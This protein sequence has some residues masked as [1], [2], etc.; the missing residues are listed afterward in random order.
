[1]NDEAVLALARRFLDDMDAHVREAPTFPLLLD[2]AV[3]RMEFT[4]ALGEEHHAEE[5]F[6]AAM[7]LLRAGGGAG[8]WLYRGAAQAGWTALRLARA[9]GT[10]PAGLGAVDDTVLR[11]ITDYPA[12]GEVDLPMGVLGL[13]VY[14]LAHPDAGFRDKA[15]AG[16]LDVVEERVERDD[17]G[18]FL[19]LSDSA[20][21]RAD[22]SALCRVLG[23][24]HG[25]AGLVSYLASAA[26]TACAP[27][28]RPL[29]D[30]TV[31]WLR[32]RRGGFTHSVFPHRVETRYSPARAT[33]CSGDPGIALALTAAAG[34]TRDPDDAELAR[35]TAAA[36]VTRPE[37]DCGIM[38]G[39]VCHGAAGLVWFGRRAHDDH[40]L[41]EGLECARRWTLWLARRREE[42]PLT[43]ANPAGMVRD[44]SF[45]EGDA[46]VALSL[47]YAAT[48]TRP[49]WEQLVLAAPVAPGNG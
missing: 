44:A 5:S 22:G 43:Y 37:E 11:W 24:A 39:C 31:R 42:G 4:R 14:A 3:T 38:D 19:R 40:G 48:G 15:T 1:M 18:L 2:Q 46:G 16:V 41:A 45:L 27:R 35:E 10:E 6:A 25:T 29:L 34:V 30:G 36:V 23:A 8:P 17:D 21:R 9:R 12:E 26:G 7:D 33:W 28:A 20:A 32:A 49:D 13:G 47:L